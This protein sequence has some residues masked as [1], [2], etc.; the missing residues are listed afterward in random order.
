MLKREGQTGYYMTRDGGDSSIVDP[1]YELRNYYVAR[2][3]LPAKKYYVSKLSYQRRATTLLPSPFD[4]DCRD[5]AGSRLGSRQKCI[6]DCMT[7]RSIRRLAILPT[8]VQIYSAEDHPRVPLMM[9]DQMEEEGFALAMEQLVRGCRKHCHKL[10]CRS[11]TFQ[12]I[13]T[14]SL[15]FTIGFSLTS[16][17]LQPPI[18]PDIVIHAHPAILLSDLLMIVFNVISLWTACCPLQLALHKPH[19]AIHVFFEDKKNKKK[20][21]DIIASETILKRMTKVFKFSLACLCLVLCMWQLELTAEDYFKYPTRSKVSIRSVDVQEIPSVSVCQI[22]VLYQWFK[23]FTTLSSAMKAES[24]IDRMVVEADVPIT[25]QRFFRGNYACLTINPGIQTIKTSDPTVNHM[26]DLKLSEIRHMMLPLY[27]HER[28]SKI[29]GNYDS[30]FEMLVSMNDNF[31]VRFSKYTSILLPAP[32]DTDCMDYAVTEYDSVD[33]CIESCAVNQSLSVIGQFPRFLSAAFRNS[34]DV[35][36]DPILNISRDAYLQSHCNNQCPKPDC[37]RSKYS[38]YPLRQE[39]NRLMKRNPGKKG[40]FPST[41]IEIMT[42]DQP[43]HLMESV[44]V[45]DVVTFA[46]NFLGC[47]TFWT[48]LCPFSVLLAKRILRAVRFSFSYQNKVWRIKKWIR[49]FYVAIVVLLALSAYAYQVYKISDIY[50][51]YATKNRIEYMTRVSYKVP[52]IDICHRIEANASL[53]NMLLTEIF[54]EIQTHKVANESAASMRQYLMYNLLCHSLTFRGQRFRGRELYARSLYRRDEDE[55]QNHEMLS[56]QLSKY[57]QDHL[58]SASQ[59]YLTMHN[60]NVAAYDPSNNMIRIGHAKRIS[61]FFTL[62]AVIHKRMQRPY[63]TDCLKDIGSFSSS[64]NCYESC[65]SL[66]F[67]IKYASLPI[68]SPV[69]LPREKGEGNNIVPVPTTPQVH[70][71][72]KACVATCGTDCRQTYYFMSIANQTFGVTDYSFTFFRPHEV[73][74]NIV[75]SAKT[76]FADFLMVVLNGGSF[77]L[78]FCPATFLFS[79]RFMKKMKEKKPGKPKMWGIRRK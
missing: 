63:D 34:W 1:A 61:A 20:N 16:L 75:Y 67:Q 48:G 73:V 7:E 11:E 47:I 23:N 37:V 13:S 35:P 28:D 30:Y 66:M 53:K 64:R 68:D 12:P 36:F 44:A 45:Y 43:I 4:T 54:S 50:F 14:S 2:G 32:Y 52:T 60:T 77:W 62:S 22:S 78:A 58:L 38:V 42:S 65:Y 24:Y 40:K 18:E 71:I 76:S 56:I 10:D 3:F 39:K 26:F 19:G 72:R 15:S 31:K 57:V 70:E 6:N 55:L 51:S 49:T 79:H 17:T 69:F 27:V 41:R 8:N 46:T 59:I 21:M 25:R 74:T 33:D 9:P 5:Y 29:C